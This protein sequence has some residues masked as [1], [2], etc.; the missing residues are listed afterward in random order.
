MGAGVASGLNVAHRA[1]GVL[2]RTEGCIPICGPARRYQKVRQ[3]G[4]AAGS[5]L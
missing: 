2:V 1:W 3:R 5:W 4:A